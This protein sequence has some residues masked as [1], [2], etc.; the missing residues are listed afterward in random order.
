MNVGVPEATVD[1][2]RLSKQLISCLK[3]IWLKH[4]SSACSCTPA[5]V[6][7]TSFFSL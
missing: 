1:V 3:I 2:V 6:G 4:L 5:F 7:L